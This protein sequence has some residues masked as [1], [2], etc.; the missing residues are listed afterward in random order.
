MVLWLLFSHCVG[1]VNQT[2]LISGISPV[3][4]FLAQQGSQG[5]M[6]SSLPFL[7]GSFLSP[8][9][10][11]HILVV[12]LELAVRSLC[13]VILQATIQFSGT[14]CS[15][16]IIYCLH[17]TSPSWFYWRRHV[18]TAGRQ[19]DHTQADYFKLNTGVGA[20]NSQWHGAN[21]LV[22]SNYTV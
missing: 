3:V 11:V 21:T 15:V 18:N 22:L 2:G 8:A 16:R 7:S 13:R 6:F 1:A 17:L 4:F 10:R 12:Y 5:V 9:I 19:A 20:L 14:K